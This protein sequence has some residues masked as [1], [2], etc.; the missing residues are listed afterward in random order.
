M[1]GLG[2]SQLN[3]NAEAIPQFELALR[4]RPD[5]ASARF[6]LANS[7]AKTGKIEAA[8][9][10]LRQILASNPSDPYAQKRLTELS[11]IQLSPNP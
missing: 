6:N 3:R 9:A 8:I 1:L 11:G 10:N 7:L 2:L 4:Q 5:Y